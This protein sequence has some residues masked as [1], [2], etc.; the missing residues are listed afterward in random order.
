MVLKNVEII[1]IRLYTFMKFQ[2]QSNV[3]HFLEFP[4][5]KIGTNEYQRNAFI[6]VWK[7]RLFK[8]RVN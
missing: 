1:N 7:L 6:M 3:P 4:A 8:G 2:F 5:L